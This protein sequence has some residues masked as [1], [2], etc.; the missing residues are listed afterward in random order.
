MKSIKRLL[1]L[2]LL[3]SMVNV[4]AYASIEELGVFG[5]V[6]AGK[7]LP[8]T[9]E[10]Y[11]KKSKS[12]AKSYPYKEVVFISG[13]P[14]ELEGEITIKRDTSKVLKT[15]SGNYKE[16]IEVKLENKDGD[17]IKRKISYSVDYQV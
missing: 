3:L 15:E 12:K 7:N 9:I 6:S 11:V 1:L 10:K 5:G 4:N 13:S 16:S 17:K 8:K 2:V 14:V